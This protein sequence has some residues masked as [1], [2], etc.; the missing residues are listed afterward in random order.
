MWWKLLQKLQNAF[1]KLLLLS[2]FYIWTLNCDSLN[3]ITVTLVPLKPSAEKW[4]F[5]NVFLYI[6]LHLLHFL[7][8]YDTYKSNLNWNLLKTNSLKI[9]FYL[10]YFYFK[11]RFINFYYYF[12]NIYVILFGRW[13]NYH[14]RC[15]M[16]SFLLRK[17]VCINIIVYKITNYINKSSSHIGLPHEGYGD[18]IEK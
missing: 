14:I 8:L 1:I 11:I 5:L 3:C 9:F 12:T 18:I 4:I 10:F 6:F 16:H 2:K 15:I 7:S 13:E 17:N